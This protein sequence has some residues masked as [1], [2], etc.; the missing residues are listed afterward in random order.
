MFFVLSNRIH[1]ENK[2]I[3]G[4][5]YCGRPIYGGHGGTKLADAIRN[6]DWCEC[7]YKGC[8]DENENVSNPSPL[9]EKKEQPAI[10]ELLTK[11]FDQLKKMNSKLDKIT[12]H[13]NWQEVKD[14]ADREWKRNMRS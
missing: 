9:P 10:E 11:V 12:D 14:D 8:R 13:L 1:C 7:C 4:I 2:M 6:Y 5:T 3:P